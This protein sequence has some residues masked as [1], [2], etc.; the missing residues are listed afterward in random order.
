MVEENMWPA[1]AVLPTGQTLCHDAAGKLVPCPG[2][3]QDA[4]FV[5]ARPDR[6][7]RFAVAAEGLV[8]DRAT[9]LLWPMDAGLSGFPRP[10]SEA[11]A[12]VAGYARDGLLGR[13]DW[14]LPNRRELRSL[15]SYGAA[16]PA[17]PSGHLFQN[18]FI[19]WYWS[20]TTAAPAPAYAWY[21]HLEGGRMF[22]GKKDQDCLVWPV[23]GRSHLPQTGQEG[24]Y[25][26]IGREIPCA[27]TGQD[28]AVRSGTPWPSPRFE[29]QGEAVHDRLTGLV[30]AARADIGG[31]AATWE[32]ALALAGRFGDGG[33]RLPTINELESLVDAGRSHPALP[34]GHPFAGVGEAYWSSTTSAFENNWA[35]ALYLHKGAVGVGVKSAREFLVWPVRGPLA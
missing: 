21:V 26:V 34:A 27:G 11:L 13:T 33:W 8:G 4:A 17:L 14:H 28:G 6:G 3:G 19:G 10:W 9:G 22:Y 1:T 12:L 15:I 5:V 31:G 25:D 20:A 30:W 2:S 32:Q 23:A 35:H 18:V 7:P 16:R 24:C 29:K